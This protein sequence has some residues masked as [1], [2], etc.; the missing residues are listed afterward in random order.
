[1]IS[2]PSLN[3]EEY[4]TKVVQFFERQDD[5]SD[6]ALD[7]LYNRLSLTNFKFNEKHVQ[8]VERMIKYNIG[9]GLHFFC[10]IE[11]LIP[12]ANRSNYVKQIVEKI[13][14]VLGKQ[15]DKDIKFNSAYIHY[16]KKVYPTEASA[17]NVPEDRT[18]FDKVSFKPNE[19]FSVYIW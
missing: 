10:M 4:Y 2:Q 15:Q 8:S 14:Q 1:M 17:L 19:E 13:T 18:Y 5:T 9:T 7:Q 11:Q 3:D 16:L 12:E 6:G